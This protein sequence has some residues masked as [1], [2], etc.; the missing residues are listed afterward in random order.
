MSKLTNVKRAFLEGVKY[1]YRLAADE[2]RRDVEDLIDQLRD[3]HD[4]VRAELA[5][6]CAIKNIIDTERDPDAALN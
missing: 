2:T 3:A 5:L 4:E 6:M 1:G